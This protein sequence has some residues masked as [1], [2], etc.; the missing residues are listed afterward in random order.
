MNATKRTEKS[1]SLWG[2]SEDE[3]KS[4]KPYESDSWWG[5]YD[6]RMER[7]IAHVY[8]HLDEPLD[9]MTLADV[10]G[11]SP[12]H[13]HRIF[14]SMY[15][16]SLAATVKRLRLHRAAGVLAHSTTPI[17]KVALAA[18]YPNVQ[19]F[20]RTFGQVYGMPPA[21]YRAKGHHT[22]FVVQ[23]NEMEPLAKGRTQWGGLAI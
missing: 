2:S 20:T 19:S 18:G 12:F 9:L 3:S 14:Q 5:R 22:R 17:D 10:A 16:E 11:M 13:W 21:R 7:V 15:G 6:K 8:D 1:T 23:P 4:S